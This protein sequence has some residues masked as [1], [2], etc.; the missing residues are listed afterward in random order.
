M[1]FPAGYHL[2]SEVVWLL[3]Q[4]G[5]AGKLPRSLGFVH[6]GDPPDVL[7]LSAEANARHIVGELLAGGRVLAIAVFSPSGEQPG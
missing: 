7:D 5:A 4:W 2:V 1:F 3:E 6:P